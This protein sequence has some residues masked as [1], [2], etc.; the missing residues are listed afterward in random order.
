MRRYADLTCFRSQSAALIA[1]WF[2][3]LKEDINKGNPKLI[4]FIKDMGMNQSVQDVILKV[5]TT[6]MLP[7]F[8]HPFYLYIISYCELD[9]NVSLFDDIGNCTGYW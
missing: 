9:N 2:I 8:G 4:R 1:L 3:Y 6:V 7:I 5:Q